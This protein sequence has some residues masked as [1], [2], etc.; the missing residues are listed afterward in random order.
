MTQRPR[1]FG[2][3]GVRGVVGVDLNPVFISKL[4]SAIAFF[5][6]EG[7]RI[8]VG[9]DTR[10][11]GEAIQAIVTGTLQ[12]SGIKVYDAGVVPTPALQYA[13]KTQ[14]FDGGVVITASHNPPEYNGIK[15][16][17]PTGIEIDRDE[18]RVVEEY[19]WEEKYKPV[20]WRAVQNVEKYPYVNDIYVKAVVELVDRESIASRGFKVLVDPANGPGALTT[21]RILRMLGAK[22]LVINGDLSSV[23]ARLP[24]PTPE[25]LSKAAYETVA[26]GCDLGVGHDGDADR[27]IFIDEAGRVHWGDRSA[28]LLIKHLWVNRGER[29]R[30]YTGVSSS[31]IVEEVLKPLGVEVVWLK[32]GSVDIAHAM[33]RSGDALCGFEENGGFFYVKHQ[34]VRDGGMTTALFLEFMAKERRKASELFDELPRY[35]TVKTKYTM[36]RDKALMVVEKVKELFKHERLVTVDGV[37]V[38]SSD[39]WLLVR[40]SGTEPLLRVMLEAKTEDKVKELLETVDSVVKEVIKH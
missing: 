39:Y 29:G 27:A 7:S 1:L 6:G 31:I 16:I 22:P 19:F 30:V 17:G 20:D 9:R 38:I 8:L 18:E 21:P 3:D 4:A 15:V 23:P 37:K 11:G 24:E 36:S 32:V 10:A 5:F 40:P 35:I 34:Y 14:G 33:R 28:V 12:L 25:T 13:V 2:T 26:T